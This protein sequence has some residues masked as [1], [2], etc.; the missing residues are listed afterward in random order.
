M[1]EATEPRGTAP[2][3]QRGGW[4]AGHSDCSPIHKAHSRE[5]GSDTDP[6]AHRHRPV[7]TPAHHL[8]MHAVQL[9]EKS[10]HGSVSVSVALPGT[11]GRFFQKEVARRVELLSGP[12][13]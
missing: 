11:Q 7:T 8:H 2:G 12:A 13:G 10:T 6:P 4:P 3:A 5:T 9:M 1:E